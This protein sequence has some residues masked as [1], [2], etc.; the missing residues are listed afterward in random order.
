M[1]YPFWCN[2]YSFFNSKALTKILIFYPKQNCK[3]TMSNLGD[4]TKNDDNKD[5]PYRKFI[6]GPSRSGKTI[7]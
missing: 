3:Y 2:L 5:W 6:I 1:I 4:I 7:Y